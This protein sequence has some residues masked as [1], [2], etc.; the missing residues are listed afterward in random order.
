MSILKSAL[1]TVA[2]TLPIGIKNS[3]LHLAFNIARPEF[4]RFSYLYSHA[5]NMEMGLSALA[6]RGIQPANIIDVGAFEGDWSRMARSIWPASKVIMFEP[7]AAKSDQVFRASRAIDAT[8]FQDLL[9]ANDGA[10]VTFNIM[11]SGSSIMNERSPLPR[12]QETRKLRRLDT[13]IPHLEGSSFLKIDAQGY[14]LE[15]LR[16]AETILPN[17]DVILLEVSVIEINEGA[18]LVSDV[19][20]FMKEIGFVTCEI[21]EIHRRPLDQALNQIDMIFVREDSKLFSD[22]RHFA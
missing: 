9:G 8:L 7:N 13:V 12:V 20:T 1:T 11:E 21:L 5:P 15:I 17:I 18:P 22:K 4:D 3:L 2:N 16:G 19:T 6:R 10:E 14:E